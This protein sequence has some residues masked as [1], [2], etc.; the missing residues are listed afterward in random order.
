MIAAAT[1]GAT[2]GATATDAAGADST[3]DATAAARKNENA[4]ETLSPKKAK[5]EPTQTKTLDAHC[6]DYLR[7]A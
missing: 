7:S 2:A 1:A 3:A 5:P 4:R 6:F